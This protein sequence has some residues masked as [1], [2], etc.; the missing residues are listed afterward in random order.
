MLFA[1]ERVKETTT[2]VSSSSFVLAG[3]VSGFQGFDDVHTDDDVFHVCIT[4]GT[5]WVRA[6]ARYDGVDTVDLLAVTASSNGGAAVSFGAGTK[7]IFEAPVSLQANC[8]FAEAFG[9]GSDGDL[10]ISSGT[11]TATALMCFQTLTISGTGKY[12]VDIYSPVRGFLLDLDNA[13]TSA[14]VGKIQNGT[15][16]VSTTAGGATGALSPIGGPITSVGSRGGNGATGNGS[17]GDNGSEQNQIHPR[18]S[19]AGA[20]GGGGGNGTGGRLGGTGATFVSIGSPTPYTMKAA[21]YPWTAFMPPPNTTRI[22][23]NRYS[24]LGGGGGAGDGTNAG[25]G[26]GGGASAGVYLGLCFAAISRGAST[27]SEAIKIAGGVGGNGF[28]PTTGNAGGGGG[29]GGGMGGWVRI[30]C[31]KLIGT[32]KTDA[33]SAP[34]GTGGDGGNGVGTGL[35]GQGGR[36][37]AG[38][39]VV[40]QEMATMSVT[41][42]NGNDASAAPT[43]PA[44]STGSTGSAG[45]SCLA[46]L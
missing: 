10:T 28:T 29:G 30:L 31:G 4:D 22:H 14:I 45:G 32:A 7:T 3:P 21:D 20:T 9:D 39:T 15:T 24:G 16:S 41:I 26:G 25:G 34:G 2:S 43:V 38:G 19:T 11:T 42:T 35:G 44:T 37:G 36:G 27:A 18:Q 23:S 46:T 33:V 17:N 8:W 40:I 12:D 1:A 6:F 5:D 13:P